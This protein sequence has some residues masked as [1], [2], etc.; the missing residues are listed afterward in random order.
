MTDKRAAARA[1]ME[2]MMGPGF[3]DAMEGAER[4]GGFGAPIAGF[5]MEHAFADVWSRPG[6]T[7]RDRSLI[8]IAILIAQGQPAELKNHVKF[9]VNNG[10]TPKDIEEI[11]IQAYPYV[12][13]PATSTA[14][15]ATIDA[16]RAIGVDTATTTAEE[17]GLL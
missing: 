16:L 10:L 1:L 11:L 14:L 5:A 2:K 4:A 3:A 13:F 15:S 12:G 7:L 9:G 17:R 8:V 6:L